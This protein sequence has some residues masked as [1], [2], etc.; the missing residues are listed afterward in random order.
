[1]ELY[2]ILCFLHWYSDGQHYPKSERKICRRKWNS[3]VHVCHRR[4][5]SVIAGLSLLEVGLELADK[6]GDVGG[7]KS[8]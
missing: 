2:R 3:S 5:T 6:L 4:G 7:E 8:H 1:M